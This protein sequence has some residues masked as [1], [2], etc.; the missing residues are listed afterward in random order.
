MLRNILREELI[1]AHVCPASAEWILLWVKLGYLDQNFLCLV[2]RGQRLGGLLLA[3]GC[4]LELG[5]LLA[6]DIGCVVDEVG[7][8]VLLARELHAHDE[9][10]D[11]LQHKVPDEP[12]EDHIADQFDPDVE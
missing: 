10:A 6:R 1:V 11:Q 4:F 12:E 9:Q 5:L 8:F 3:R 2:Q 7:R